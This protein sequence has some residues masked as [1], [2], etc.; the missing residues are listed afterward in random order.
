MFGVKKPER[1]AIH[2]RW[3]RVLHTAQGNQEW[4]S[5]FISI[6]KPGTQSRTQQRILKGGKEMIIRVQELG[7]QCGVVCVSV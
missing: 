3:I 5:V 7:S 4:N 6:V 2:P 1:Q